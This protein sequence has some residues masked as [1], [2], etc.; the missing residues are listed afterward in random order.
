[1][2]A[3]APLRRRRILIADGCHVCTV[4]MVRLYW[5]ALSKQKLTPSHRRVT[6]SPVCSARLEKYYQTDPRES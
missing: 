5:S 3:G 1:M 6:S 2:R 4:L